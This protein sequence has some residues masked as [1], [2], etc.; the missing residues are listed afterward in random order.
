M[1][2]FNL[3]DFKTLALSL[4]VIFSLTGCGQGFQEAEILPLEDVSEDTSNEA[5]EEDVSPEEPEVPTVPSPPPV[6][7]YGSPA[8]NAQFSTLPDGRQL[9]SISVSGTRLNF[10]KG[11]GYSFTATKRQDYLSLKLATQSDP[12]HKVQWT[13][14]DLD[15]NEVLEHSLASNKKIFGA[16][17]SKI[18]VAAALLDRQDGVL[19]ESQLQLMSNMLVVSS[20]SAWT[21]LQRQIGDGSADKGRERIH[22]FTQ[23]MGYP[24]T[25]GFQGYWGGIHGNELV[26]DETAQMLYDMYTGAFKGAE[27]EWKLLHACRTGASRGRK[28]IPTTIYVGGKTGTYD[29]PTENPQT[30]T[31]YTVKIRNHV[32]T[33]NVDGKQYGL[34]IFANNGSDESVALLAGGLIRDYTSLE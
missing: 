3:P 5:S 31:Q 6:F 23:A 32:M 18:Y 14:I 28:Y 8:T 17:S 27:L 2:H 22:N 16:S 29:G 30:G 26:P 33:F 24:L 11:S 9:S 10:A 12:T 21:E 25:R 1:V 20:N 34:V 15:N 4:V 19:S 13:F 7:N